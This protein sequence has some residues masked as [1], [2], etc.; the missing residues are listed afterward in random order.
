ML[1]HHSNKVVTWELV[2]I[3]RFCCAKS[4]Q[5]VRVGV[6]G[7]S[8]LYQALWDDKGYGFEPVGLVETEPA[9]GSSRFRPPVPLEGVERG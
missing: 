6:V 4:M 8:R 1:K 5:I 9:V 2:Y 3:I 7:V